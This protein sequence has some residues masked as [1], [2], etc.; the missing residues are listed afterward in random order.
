MLNGD[1][2]PSTLEGV[3]RLAAQLR[4]ERGIKHANALDVAARA[5]NCANYSH[6]QRTL[7]ALRLRSEQHFVLLTVYWDDRDTHGIGRETLRIELPKPI[8]D[9]CSKADLKQVRGFGWMRMVA[10]DHFVSD[11][12]AQSKSFARDMIGKA[13][14]SLRFMEHTGLRPSRDSKAAYPDRTQD[15]KLP[16]ADHSTC[17]YD[18]A[19]GQFILVDEPY[20]NVPDDPERVAW[21]KRHGWDLRM[22]T[23]PG[24]YFPHRCGFYV[25]TDGRQG[26]DFSA[27]MA[28]V[29]AIPA[30]AVEAEWAGES[31]P[32]HEVFVSP[33]ARTKQDRRRARSKGTVMPMTTDTTIPYSA[34]F[35]SARRRPS[36]AMGVPGHIEMGQIL[37]AV[38]HSRHRPWGAYQRIDSVRSTLEDWMALEIGNKELDGPEFFDVYYND[39]ASGGPYAEAAQS[40]G[41]L[42]CIL[43]ELKTMLRGAYPDCTPLR[44]QLHKVDMAVSLIERMKDDTD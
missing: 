32:N 8:L 33:A 12:L 3:K 2:R 42:V 1:V 22:S 17:W 9:I 34:M 26:F 18:P 27:L 37:K 15:T 35:G 19:T 6:A 30:A 14:R 24:I 23:W 29:D 5:A 39:T 10:P 38:L 7:P 36:G 20:S 13:E 25:A 44:Q 28:K 43:G 40:R 11:S 41:G 16:K 4:K 31:V 21:A